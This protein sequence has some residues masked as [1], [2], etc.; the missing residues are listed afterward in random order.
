M[1]FVSLS[2]ELGLALR[3]LIRTVWQNLLFLSLAF[4]RMCSFHVLA[5]E[6][7]ILWTFSLESQLVRITTHMERLLEGTEICLGPGT[8]CCSAEIFVPGQIPP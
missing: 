2:L 1:T 4:K 5:L 8:L 3:Y 7:L 6:I